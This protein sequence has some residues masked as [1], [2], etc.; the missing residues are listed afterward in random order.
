LTGIARFIQ[1]RVT[2]SDAT[3]HLKT[4]GKLL[5][6]LEANPLDTQRLT[7]ARQELAAANADF[8]QLS[9]D[10][11][12]LRG[13]SF[14]PVVGGKLISAGRLAPIAITATQAGMIGCDM[15]LTLATKLKDPFGGN[16]SGLTPDDWQKVSD[17][18][19]QLQGLFNTVISQINA[20][21]PAD[22]SL[23]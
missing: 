17:D 14:L 21:Q 5:K 15:L 11:N 2:L 12:L 8:T 13:A 6:G 9:N 4:T 3:N 1:D 22:L 20:L 23:D 7:Q 18:F 19:N 16:A 10:V